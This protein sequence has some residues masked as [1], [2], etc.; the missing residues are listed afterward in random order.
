MI[1]SSSYLFARQI[2]KGELPPMPANVL[3]ENGKFNTALM[4]PGFTNFND[5]LVT[6]T[7]M[8]SDY[9]IM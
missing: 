7:G 4:P 3:F 1:I 5:M 2:T 9:N 8:A 6:Y